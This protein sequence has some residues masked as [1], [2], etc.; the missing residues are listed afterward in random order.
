[1]CVL[2]GQRERGG[3]KR[4]GAVLETKLG[5]MRWRIDGD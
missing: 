4:K 1:M 5:F 2:G 3:K